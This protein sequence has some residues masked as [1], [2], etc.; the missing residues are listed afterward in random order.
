MQEA[1]DVGYEILE[2]LDTP[3]SLTIYMMVKYEE[4]DQLK[5]ISI[6]PLH[7]CCPKRFA[8]DYQATSLLRK[9][10][11]LPRDEG[12]LQ[13]DTLKKW[14]DCEHSC[15]RTNFFLDK[16]PLL[17]GAYA[18]QTRVILT[19]A[20]RWIRK[21]L[22]PL[23][24]D[25]LPKFGPGSNVSVSSRRCDVI[26]KISHQNPT[27]TRSLE[28][29]DIN[30]R[31][32]RLYDG[33]TT[34]YIRGNEYFTVPKDWKSYRPCSKEPLLNSCLQL[35]AGTYI[36][37]M[38]K[39]TGLDLSTQAHHQS[40]A[41]EAS[42]SGDLSTL[43][44][45]SASD[46]VCS[47]LIEELLPQQWFLLLND[48]RS[49]HT[50]VNGRYVRLEKFSSM[51]NGFTFELET[52]VFSAIIYG[53]TGLPTMN[54]G[55]DGFS[56][57]GDDIIVPTAHAADV[58]AALRT[59]GF[60]INQTKSF[61]SGPFRESCGG[62]FYD[63]HDCRPYRAG[64]DPSK[65]ADWFSIHNGLIAWLKRQDINLDSWIPLLRKLRR[66][67]SSS[68]RVSVPEELGDVGF[69]NGTP[70]WKVKNSIRYVKILRSI[71]SQRF[72][73]KDSHH[74]V[75]AQ[76]LGYSFDTDWRDKRFLVQRGVKF[77]Y[78]VGWTPF[79]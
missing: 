55:I 40:L 13:Q 20:R 5:L 54:K 35:A 65:P 56:V 75:T 19:R 58:I 24:Q 25:L 8:V 9:S 72:F 2:L 73:V 50:K 45:S 16:L 26:T 18:E 43:D 41:K 7:Y 78:R 36:R 60:T 14:F 21:V 68:L 31:N 76:L 47:V 12:K 38:L 28:S 44:L 49:S 42:I 29:W 69:H 77:Q 3:R 33:T 15:F 53:V 46:T 52:L 79:S 10:D 37:K 22:G 30:L 63:G 48:L 64:S 57:Y 1:I 51:G 71:P 17:E 61:T 34:E 6:D 39:R 74:A 67:V 62:D 11:W 27:A 70:L 32:F 59:F 4:L 23:P 66:Q